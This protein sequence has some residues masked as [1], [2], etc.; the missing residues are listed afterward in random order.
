MGSWKDRL[1]IM[2][3]V[4]CAIHCAATPILIA[5]LP[6]LKLTEWMAG[7]AFHQWAA[8]ICTGLVAIA[9]VPSFLKSWD[10]RVL[11]LSLSGIG[12]IVTAAFFMPD[13]CCTQ[14]LA[15]AGTTVSGANNVTP[16]PHHA[17]DHHGHEHDGHSHAV[18]GHDHADADDAHGSDAAMV[19]IAGVQPWLTPLGGM[20]LILAHGLNLKHRRRDPNA[21]CPAPSHAVEGYLPERLRACDVGI[22]SGR[23]FAQAS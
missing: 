19:S 13:T 23:E 17:H 15:A 11:G 7:P 22:E 5:S 4:I 9:I 3:S 2:A 10:Y 14:P 16:G 1:G 20:L 6:T 21:C 18:A 12:L 8:A